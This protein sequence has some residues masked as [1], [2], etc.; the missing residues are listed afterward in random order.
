MTMAIIFK[1][2]GPE[3]V[4]GLEVTKQGLGQISIEVITPK[5]AWGLWTSGGHICF[6][7]SELGTVIE[8]LESY[9]KIIQAQDEYTLSKDSVDLA[10]SLS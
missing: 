8:A 1:N 2:T 7:A 3:R 10:M 4:Y 9:R 6:P 5:S